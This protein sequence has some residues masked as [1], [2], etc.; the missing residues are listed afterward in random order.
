MAEGICRN[1]G[2][3]DVIVSFGPLGDSHVAVQILSS[4]SKIDVPDEWRYL[5]QAWAIERVYCN[6]ASLKDHEIRATHNSRIAVL[7]MGSAVRK[8]HLY[9]SSIRIPLAVGS[10]KAWKVLQQQQINL[11]ASK[12]Y[13]SRRCAQTFP[14][15]KIK[16]FRERMYV[17]TTF[18]FRRHLK[19]DVHPQSRTDHDGRKVVTL[20]GVDVCH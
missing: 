6:G 16:L 19:L 1:V 9:P 12:D 14:R 20:E 8:S 18:Q 13:C 4:L 7:A 17:G 2:S 5:V 10:T 11:V 15:E 3:D